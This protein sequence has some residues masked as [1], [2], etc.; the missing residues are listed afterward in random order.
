MAEPTKN[1]VKYVSTK[2]DY[3]KPKT[4]RSSYDS[5]RGSAY[6]SK[7]GEGLILRVEGNRIRDMRNNTYYRIQGNIVH[8]EGSG[9][10]FE[11]SGNRIRL[12]FGN[13]L[14]ELSGGNLNK[15]Y[16]GYFASVD[17]GRITKHDLSEIY[18]I[19]GS[20]DSTQ[21]LVVAALI[22]GAY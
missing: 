20:L 22:F 8:Q 10:V 12:A 17:G 21:K 18:E 19:S 11:I 13:Y 3:S 2:R 5:D 7:V 6:I 15:V 4:N 9:P 1:D 16:G 14:Y